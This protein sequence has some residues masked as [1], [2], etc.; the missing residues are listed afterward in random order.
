MLGRPRDVGFGGRICSI[1]LYVE[2]SSVALA[3]KLYTSRWKE[4]TTENA[5][6][7]GEKHVKRHR[8]CNNL[9]GWFNRTDVTSID[10]VNR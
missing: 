4:I 7:L 9:I 8:A 5:V 3:L 2:G 6:R 10:R 1:G